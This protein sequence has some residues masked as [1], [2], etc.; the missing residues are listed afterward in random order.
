MILYFSG[1]GNSRFV[2]QQISKICED[3]LV[4]I[5]RES[6][7]RILDPYNAVYS[8]C[9]DRPY[10][11]VCPTYCWHV[12]Q[13]VENFLY[14]SRLLGSR[15]LYFFLTCGS[16]TGR[17][18]AHAQTI[19]RKLEKNFM[20]LSSALMPEN[21]ICLFRAPDAD[22]AVG[23]IRAAMAQA[24]TAA[25]LILSGRHITDSN[26]GHR[27]P[28]FACRLF[29]R[30]FVTDKLFYAKSSCTGCGT[31]AKLCPM[32]NIRIV[33]SKPQWN[34]NCTQCQACIAVCPEDAIEFGNRSRRKRR[35][36]LFAD[37]RQKFSS[38]ISE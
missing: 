3:E 15:D 11:V 22:E 27:M 33:G 14:D 32:A 26:A 10:V 6:R 9:S 30:Y 19:A 24:E 20:G 29:Y 28:D 2:A 37:G 12:P 5:N 25:H 4:S 1:T 38:E 8:F 13:I 23:V 18:D 36:Y 17:A 16:G 21:Y 34:G 35:Y 7:R 31:C